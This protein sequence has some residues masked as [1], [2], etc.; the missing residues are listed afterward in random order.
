MFGLKKKGKPVEETPVLGFVEIK[1]IG[2]V[3]VTSMP[4]HIPS[5]VLIGN[6]KV[7]IDR[8]L[9]LWL[10][11]NTHGTSDGQKKLSAIT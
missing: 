10:W 3:E 8:E 9:Y 7:K 1:G 6:R 5:H 11:A 4:D 2:K